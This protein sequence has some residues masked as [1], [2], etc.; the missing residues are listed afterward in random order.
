MDN[1]SIEGDERGTYVAL[2]RIRPTECGKA[3]GTRVL[4]S[5]SARSRRGSD[6]P[7]GPTGEPLT[8][9][10]GTGSQMRSSCTVREMRRAKQGYSSAEVDSAVA[11]GELRDKETVMRRSGRGG[12]KRVRK[13]NALAA[14]STHGT[15]CDRHSFIAAWIT[16]RSRS[17]V[18]SCL[19]DRYI[20]PCG[21]HADHAQTVFLR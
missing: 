8:G 2:E 5:R 16:L 20:D 7:P 19:G 21:Q 10:R 6:D 14:Y 3:Y 9:R 13:D 18:G 12:E 4:G 17:I 15:P 1:E 11:P